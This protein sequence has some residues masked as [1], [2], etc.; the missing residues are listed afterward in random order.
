MLCRGPASS[1]PIPGSVRDHEDELS[2]AELTQSQVKIPA[3]SRVFA[4]G[5]AD[6]RRPR[7]SCYGPQVPAIPGV[8]SCRSAVW[9]AMI[10]SAGRDPRGRGDVGQ[11]PT[12]HAIWIR[13]KRMSPPCEGHRSG[14]PALPGALA[15]LS[16]RHVLRPVRANGR[17]ALCSGHDRQPSH[18]T[19]GGNPIPWYA[20]R[21]AD[22]IPV[23]L[24]QHHCE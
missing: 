12:H 15:A 22:K 16:A 18:V 7:S 5:W 20:T 9:V 14:A 23:I 6:Q 8:G 11:Q 24:E 10:G 17:D 3:R 1:L 2:L 19:G 21:G 4:E 13:E